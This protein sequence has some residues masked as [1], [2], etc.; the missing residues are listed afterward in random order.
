MKGAAYQNSEATGRS[1]SVQ[2]AELLRVPKLCGADIELGNFV[3]GVAQPSGTG[4]FASR[5]LLAEIEGLPKETQGR[6]LQCDCSMCRA[7]RDSQA[8][9]N[10]VEESREEQKVDRDESMSGFNAQDWGRKFLPANGG[11]AYIDLNHLELCLPEVISAFDHVACWHAMLRIAQRA[12]ASANETMPQGK[13]IQALVNNSDGRGK[14]YGS[15]L[16]FLITR[17]AWNNIFQRKMHYMLYLAAFQASSIIYTGQGKVGSENGAEAV[18]FQIAQRAD[19][20]EELVGVQTTARRPLVNSRDESLCGGFREDGKLARLHVIFFDNTLSQVASLLKVGVTQIVLAMIE[21]EMIN[22]DLI[23]DDPVETLVSWSHDPT[24]ESRARLTSGREVTAVELQLLF[25]EEAKRFI[26]RGG[27]ESFV[28]RVEEIMALWE[29]TLLKLQARDWPQLA[30]RLDWVLKLSILE[31]VLEHRPEL[32]WNAPQL[33]HLDHAYSSLDAAE[34]LYWAYERSG[35]VERVVAEEHI[36]HFTENPPADTRAWT[37]AMLLRAVDPEVLDD[38]NWDFLSFKQQATRGRTR[39][40]MLEMA[41]PLRF[42]KAMSEEAFLES[43]TLDE[44]LD[45]LGSKRTG[46]VRSNGKQGTVVKPARNL[47]TVG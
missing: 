45:A 32:D 22:P 39:T 9:D 23:L 12:L 13:Q 15:H 46:S 36:E 25:L 37:R 5:A 1:R 47:I 2:T 10:V 31:Q 4:A 35:F 33:K 38:V 42:N 21:A 18:E 34:G 30:K 20:F 6:G 3:L 8:D 41:N 28:P 44:L 26:A 40:R 11:C 7:R 16:N 19:F 43:K 17:R 27:C 29:D 14:S 24:L